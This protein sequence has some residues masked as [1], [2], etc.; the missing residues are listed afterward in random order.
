MLNIADT[1]LGETE[2][3]LLSPS[4][5]G[6]STRYRSIHRRIVRNLLPSF[7]F[8]NS[9]AVRDEIRPTDFLDGMRGYAAFI[10]Y[11]CHFFMPTHPQATRG[12]NGYND[13][14]D[15]WLTQLPIIRLIYSG[16]VSVSL[17]FVISGF[18]ISLKPLKLI[19]NGS[20]SAFLDTMVSATFRRPCRL[21]LPC[22]VTLAITFLVACC[23]AFDFSYALT[24]NWPFLSKPLRIP[25]AHHSLSKQ[26]TDWAGQVWT[27]S[28]PLA[29]RT[30][31]PPYGVQLWTIPIELSCSFISFLALIG[32][33]KVRQAV[34]MSI[35]TTIAVYFLFQ[36]H[37]EATLFLAGTTLAELY[38]I[39]QESA[40][41][42]AAAA[43]GRSTESRE[44]KIQSS[45]L[46]GFGMFVASYPTAEG[47]KALFS[48][49]L[50]YVASTLFGPSIRCPNLFVTIGTVILVYVVS[51]SP[52]LQ[53]MFTTQLAKYLGKISFALY[54]VHQAMINSFGY[55]SML[56]LWSFT[57]NDTV[58]RYELGLFLSW[59]VQ[60]TL[61]IW[62][63]DVFWRF[64]DI[65]SVG[66][67]RRLEEWCL[68][69]S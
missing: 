69:N 55:R 19:R 53:T 67:S 23:G 50:H 6:V 51:R 25:I 2:K 14:Q 31:H 5:L 18:S 16:H 45:L 24:K 65:P 7:L 62:A 26:F 44:Q 52:F 40:A 35:T 21:Y 43:P 9:T 64:V 15:Y 1:T 22:L 13:D 38:L 60:T 61:T 46:F 8:H 29:R 27:W 33:A 58:Y 30:R 47:E 54:C 32:L 12:F 28:D 34:R 68:V 10:V 59:V 63:A 36:N 39:R 57:G 11:C 17:F 42:A 20:Y 41:A 66:I 37:P 49:P 4:L 3:G 56:F 48:A